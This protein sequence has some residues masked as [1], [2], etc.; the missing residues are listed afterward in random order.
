MLRQLHADQKLWY[1]QEVT[2]DALAYFEENPHMQWGEHN[3]RKGIIIT[4]VPYMT[5]RM[6]H[7]KSETMKRYYVCHCPLVREVI[8]RGEK[9]GD[10]VC[11]C[12]LGHA[13]HFLSGMGLDGLEGEVL[14]SAVKG[15][16]SCRFIFY[17]PD[18]L[19]ANTK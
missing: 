14:E 4:K 3:G 18:T 15:D 6:L 19:S 8:R 2:D 13:S 12:S 1:T 10:D 9:L 17:L 7:A 11:Y 16:M 5:D